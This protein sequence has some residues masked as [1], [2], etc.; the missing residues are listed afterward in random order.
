MAGKKIGFVVNPI[1]GM[2]GRVGL[3]GTDGVYEEAVERGAEPV[4]RDKALSFLKK[5]RDISGEAA[6]LTAGKDMGKDVMDEV[7]LDAEVVYKPGEH[8]LSEDTK[9]ACEE[10]VQRG[11]DLVIF[12]GGDGT[13]RDVHSA[14]DNQAP[15][16]GIPSGVK[17]HSAVFA[18]NPERGAEVL[19]EFLQDKMEVQECEI[20]DLDEER[21]RKGEWNIKLFG[22]AHT[23]YEPSYVQ[24][25]KMMVHCLDDKDVKD[26]I[27]T[28]VLEEMDKHRER[29]YLMGP[30]S[31][32]NHITSRL[33]LEGTILGVDCIAKGK[34]IARDVA[35]SEILDLMD[36]YPNTS[37]V[38]SPIGAQGFVFGRGNLQLSC[39]VVNKVHMSDILIVSTPAKLQRTP[40]LRVDFDDLNLRDKF[41]SKKYLFVI[42]GYH[43]KVM[44]PIT[45]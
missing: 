35:E 36:D 37:I 8:T 33:G 25:G 28:Y 44:R 4:A 43:I 26:G 31:T 34:M 24:S 12:C 32:V 18:V 5:F 21:Y 17:M 41:K 27:A 14:V 6:W 39:K 30:G 40:K 2:G 13:A 29:L 20:M 23:P 22:L 9:N 38:I 1:A 42:T 7:G 16:L 3:K 19:S 11:A 45:V 15:I 10:F